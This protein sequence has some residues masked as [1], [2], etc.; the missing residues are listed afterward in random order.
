VGDS[1][2]RP[3]VGAHQDGLR[4][5][6][7]SRALG[8]LLD[9]LRQSELWHY[10]RIQSA[11]DALGLPVSGV[12]GPRGCVEPPRDA[13]PLLHRGDARWRPELAG[14]IDVLVWTSDA[15]AI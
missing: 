5:A 7:R 9:Q 12:D 14:G 4:S 10:L 11:G 6:G 2:W 1:R 15:R 8:L 3:P 13:A